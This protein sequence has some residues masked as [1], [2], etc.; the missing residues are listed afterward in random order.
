MLTKTKQEI[1]VRIKRMRKRDMPEVLSIEANSFELPWHEYDFISCLC[2]NN[3]KGIIAKAEGKVV[4]F[5]IYEFNKSNIHVLNFAVL[6]DKLRRGIGSQMM[7][8]LTAMLSYQR[9]RILLEVRETNLPAQLF[10][11]EC[12]FKAVNVL[13]KYY[14]DTSDDAYVMQ[15]PI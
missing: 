8:K 4:G 11:R 2:D 14:V 3:C 1:R 10:F 9:R 5:M 15:Y 7:A 6:P 12:G 13:R